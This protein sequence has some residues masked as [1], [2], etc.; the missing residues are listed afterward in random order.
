[1]SRAR[2]RIAYL[3]DRSSRFCWADIVSWALR[4]DGSTPFPSSSDCRA[5][6][7]TH[8]DRTCYCGKF[9]NGELRRKAAVESAGAS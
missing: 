2:W 3:L 4:S 1:M 6:S 8:R 9:C 7:L 5:E